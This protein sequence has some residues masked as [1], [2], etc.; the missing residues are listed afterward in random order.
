MPAL[1]LEK[2]IEEPEPFSPPRQFHMH[3]YQLF[4][5]EQAWVSSEQLA[6]SDNI[7]GKHSFSLSL[8]CSVPMGTRGEAISPSRSNFCDGFFFLQQFPDKITGWVMSKSRVCHWVK[9]K[10]Y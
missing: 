4:R 1:I 7:K 3:P 2:K 9:V 8:I 6:S 5:N 10:L